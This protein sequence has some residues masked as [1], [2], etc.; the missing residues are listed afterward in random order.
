MLQSKMQSCGS[1]YPLLSR[2]EGKTLEF[3]R[4]LSPPG[5]RAEG[6]RWVCQH[7]W[8]RLPMYPKFHHGLLRDIC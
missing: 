4:D 2:P 5:Q 6:H 8:R 7:F 3:E 1:D